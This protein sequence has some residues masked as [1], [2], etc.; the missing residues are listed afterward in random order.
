MS[1]GCKTPCLE[2]RLKSRRSW[3]SVRCHALKGHTVDTFP[4]AQCFLWVPELRRQ[5]VLQEV[6]LG[7]A[8]ALLWSV[9]PALPV[10][11]GTG[12][13]FSHL[14]SSQLNGDQAPHSELQTKQGLGL[15]CQGR[16]VDGLGSRL[17]CELAGRC[18]GESRRVAGKANLSRLQRRCRWTLNPKLLNPTP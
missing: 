3:E 8:V 15:H 4:K 5:A 13:S 6:F 11:W 18:R 9:A 10:S 1:R 12:I 7:R 16:M 17:I 14:K 2:G